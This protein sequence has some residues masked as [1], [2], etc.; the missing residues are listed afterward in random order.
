M[1]VQLMHPMELQVLFKRRGEGRKTNKS[2]KSIS[3]SQSVLRVTLDAANNKST[4]TI[5]LHLTQTKGASQT[6]AEQVGVTVRHTSPQCPASPRHST[7]DAAPSSRSARSSSGLS[8]P[9]LSRGQQLTHHRAGR[10][11][12]RPAPR[13]LIPQN[14]V[15]LGGR[16]ERGEKFAALTQNRRRPYR[17]FPSRFL[18]TTLFLAW[19]GGIPVASGSSSLPTPRLGARGAAGLR[20]PRRTGK[21]REKFERGKGRQQLQPRGHLGGCPGERRRRR[22]GRA[23]CK[24][25]E[26]RALRAPASPAP[27]ACAQAWVAHRAPQSG[28]SGGVGQPLCSLTAAP[29]SRSRVP[30]QCDSSQPSPLP[31]PPF[32]G[33][34]PGHGA[35]PPRRPPLPGRRARTHLPRAGPGPPRAGRASVR[36]AGRAPPAAAA[37]R[38]C[39]PPCP[40]RLAEKFVKEAGAAPAR[41][42]G[43]SAPRPPLSPRRLA[44]RSPRRGAPAGPGAARW[45]S[46]VR[47]DERGGGGTDSPR[48]PELLC[49]RASG[50]EGGAERARPTPAPRHLARGMWDSGPQPCSG[51][52]APGSASCCRRGGSAGSDPRCPDRLR[53]ARIAFPW[54]AAA[55]HGS[56]FP[57]SVRLGSPPPSPARHSLAQRGS[58]RLDSAR[59]RSCYRRL[60]EPLALN[61]T[62]KG[63]LLLLEN[64][65]RGG[66]E[67][68]PAE[69]VGREVGAGSAAGGGGSRRW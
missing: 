43:R 23:V 36:P 5:K 49:C 10:S 41:G 2:L 44:R 45:G 69:L 17:C 13:A 28:G 40:C 19:G 64:E 33:R 51:A 35:T 38:R 34:E 62:P 18:P 56:P 14:P 8:A 47:R 31:S 3:A 4:F 54:L 68:A 61:L 63:N 16:G 67:R 1:P 50:A 11:S 32:P 57:G 21:R 25:P 15:A 7:G 58:A 39:R 42:G 26:A 20:P 46:R 12:H 29:R 22:S 6:T 59:H 30:E 60:C 37:R 55:P 24:V 48:T 52:A 65:E 53:S 66:R 9:R 27:A